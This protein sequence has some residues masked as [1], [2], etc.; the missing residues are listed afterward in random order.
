VKWGK[1]KTAVRR[2]EK[3]SGSNGKNIG[4]LMEGGDSRRKNNGKG[5][6]SINPY[7][8]GPGAGEGRLED[9]IG[10]TEKGVDVISR[11][12]LEARLWQH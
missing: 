4:S 6:F 12:P 8:G 10:D 7:F 3:N 11:F 1:E 9:K 5:L 2:Q